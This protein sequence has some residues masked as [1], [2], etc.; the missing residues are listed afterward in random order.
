MP[1]IKVNIKAIQFTLKTVITRLKWCDD[2]RFPKAVENLE[3][4][5]DYRVR[6]KMRW[7]D[8]LKSFLQIENEQPIDIETTFISRAPSKI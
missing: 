2:N 4:E 1:N 8:D 7:T 5:A 6:H 3:H